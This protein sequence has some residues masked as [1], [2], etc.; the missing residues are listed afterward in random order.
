M[1]EERLEPKYGAQ[2]GK[3]CTT[4]PTDKPDSLQALTEWTAASED[5][6][7]AYVRPACVFILCV[8]LC[9]SAIMEMMYSKSL[10]LWYRIFATTIVSE[11]VAER[12]VS[13]IRNR[14]R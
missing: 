10:G 9:A 4:M 14:K 6:V 11:W 13:K 8:T 1:S 7:R 3:Q 2:V 5:D 12:I